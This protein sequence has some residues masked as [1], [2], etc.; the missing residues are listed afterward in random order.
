MNPKAKK[1]IAISFIVLVALILIIYSIKKSNEKKAE[2]NISGGNNNSSSGYTYSAPGTAF[3]KVGTSAEKAEVLERYSGMTKESIIAD[4][5]QF[6]FNQDS[7]Y[8]A[9]LN[10]K[11]QENNK[12]LSEV[13]R[14]DAIYLL[15]TKFGVPGF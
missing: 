14:A 13:K 2:N 4:Y 15:K 11:A 8:L 7:E 10:A 12:T 6:R 9:F 3:K 5:I 1:I